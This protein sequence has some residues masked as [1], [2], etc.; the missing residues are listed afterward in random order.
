MNSFDWSELSD[1]H[2][3]VLCSDN[4]FDKLSSIKWKTKNTTIENM[5]V[6]GQMDTSEMMA[7]YSGLIQQFQ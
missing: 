7:H 6:K 5:V 1:L 3:N 2:D 4:N